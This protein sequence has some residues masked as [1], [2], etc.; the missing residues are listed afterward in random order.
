VVSQERTHGSR[1]ELLHDA[2]AL[3]AHDRAELAAELLASL[4]GLP[5]TD[6][7]GAWCEEI[8][9]R[10]RRV[11]V[12]VERWLAAPSWWASLLCSI[13]ITERD[14]RPPVRGPPPDLPPKCWSFRRSAAVA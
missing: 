10:A 1:V 12:V 2:L 14:S 4:D 9:Q 6:A 8:E 3:S 13:Q 5:D 11:A 7:E